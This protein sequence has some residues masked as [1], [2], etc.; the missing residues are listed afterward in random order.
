MKKRQRA[1]KSVVQP[2]RIVKAKIS[3]GVTAAKKPAGNVCLST[4]LEIET[5][6]E[7]NRTVAE[8]EKQRD[9]LIDMIF[10]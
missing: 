2:H 10:R 5:R 6:R 3:R 7:R 4:I 1:N 9:A 8:Y